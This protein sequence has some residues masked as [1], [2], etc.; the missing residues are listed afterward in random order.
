MAGEISVTP[1]KR[2]SEKQWHLSNWCQPYQARFH[3][4]FSLVFHAM[5]LSS[6]HLRFSIKIHIN[7]HFFIPFCIW[8]LYWC[9]KNCTQHSSIQETCNHKVFLLMTS[10]SYIAPCKSNV[11]SLLRVKVLVSVTCPKLRFTTVIIK[12]GSEE[13]CTSY[14]L[15]QRL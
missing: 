11:A 10:V 5:N 6:K 4:V 2:Y 14:I 3:A 7:M 1:Q 13:I 15:Y 8:L 9:A 12:G